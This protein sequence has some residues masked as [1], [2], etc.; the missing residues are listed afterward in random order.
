MGHW[1]LWDV[2]ALI[3]ATSEAQGQVAVT[4]ML[5]GF[6]EDLFRKARSLAKGA[7]TD[8]AGNAGWWC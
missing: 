7:I 6:E 4:A 2:K 8:R 3:T 1:H 5:L